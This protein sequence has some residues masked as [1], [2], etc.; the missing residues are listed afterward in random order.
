[1]QT[2]NIQVGLNNEPD[3]RPVSGIDL[4][5]GLDKFIPTY[6]SEYS[7]ILKILPGFYLATAW[8]RQGEA[9]PANSPASPPKGLPVI[10][11]H[12]QTRV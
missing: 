8:G 10:C 7:H 9:S 11:I 12:Y 1:M 5:L 4:W 6:Y 2:T 3:T